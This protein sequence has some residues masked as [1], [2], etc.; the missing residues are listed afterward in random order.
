MYY[1]M[2][3]NVYICIYMYVT[4]LVLCDESLEGHGC[5]TLQ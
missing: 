3:I 2:N 4:V 5:N 1:H